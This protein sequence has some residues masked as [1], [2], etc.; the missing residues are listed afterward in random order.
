VSNHRN[1]KAIPPLGMLSDVMTVVELTTAVGEASHDYQL[2]GEAPW[3]VG[4]A[5]AEDGDLR[6]AWASASDGG[7]RDVM[8]AAAELAARVGIDTAGLE[9]P[10]DAGSDAY[11]A[12]RFARDM[13][14]LAVEE[15]AMPGRNPKRTLVPGAPWEPAQGAT[16]IYAMSTVCDSTE[17]EVAK[18][19]ATVMLSA[20]AQRP[21]G[22]LP[23]RTRAAG[24]EPS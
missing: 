21:D 3:R 14:D 10:D 8:T 22:P 20:A 2:P 4:V 13:Y 6:D 5:A 17:P 23:S 15:L 16:G 1:V 9:P 12:G 19:A 18:L 7:R 11:L 24:Y